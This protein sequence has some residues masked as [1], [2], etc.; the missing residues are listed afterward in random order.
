M[1]LHSKI[2]SLLSKR[3]VSSF[4]FYGA[5]KGLAPIS[6]E[7]KMTLSEVSENHVEFT[8]PVILA[9]ECRLRITLGKLEFPTFVQSCARVSTDRNDYIVKAS[10]PSDLAVEKQLEL[11]RLIFTLMSGATL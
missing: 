10:I 3:Y 6:L 11:R 8:S 7:F 1:V 4:T 5:D 9:K 2:E